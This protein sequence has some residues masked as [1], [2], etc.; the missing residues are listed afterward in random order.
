[1]GWVFFVELEL[2]CDYRFANNRWPDAELTRDLRMIH[3]CHHLSA[4]DE[5]R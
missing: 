3:T 2:S 1:M 5:R 4:L